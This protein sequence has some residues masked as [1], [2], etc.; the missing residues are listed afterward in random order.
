MPEDEHYP[1]TPADLHGRISR[2]VQPLSLIASPQPS[3]YLIFTGGSSR[4]RGRGT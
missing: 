1:P 2:H 3:Q 4:G